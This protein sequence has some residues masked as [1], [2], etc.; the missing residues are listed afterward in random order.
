MRAMNKYRARPRPADAAQQR[1]LARAADA[2]SA[3][4]LRENELAHGEWQAVRRYVRPRASARTSAW[5]ARCNPSAIVRMWMN[6][7]PHRA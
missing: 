4:M 5:M 6:S 1:G 2:H 3:T 7:S